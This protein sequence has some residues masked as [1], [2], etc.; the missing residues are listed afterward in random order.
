MSR[1][2]PPWTVAVLTLGLAFSATRGLTVLGTG[3][4]LAGAVGALAVVVL[5]RVDVALVAG[6]L[7]QGTLPTPTWGLA[8]AGLAGLAALAI[9]VDEARLLALGALGALLP[10]PGGHLVPLVAAGLVWAWAPS[11]WRLLAVPTAAAALARGLDPLAV[12][13]GLTVAAGAGEAARRVANARANL[14]AARRLADAGLV[15]A[16]AVGLAGLLAATALDPQ[17]FEAV[18]RWTVWALV[19]GAVAG[20]AHVGAAGSLRADTGP[21]ILL[22]VAWVPV[23]AALGLGLAARVDVL[24]LPGLALLGLATPA[25]ALGLATLLAGP[26]NRSGSDATSGERAV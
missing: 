13:V 14:R 22:A 20:L 15:A 6:G 2:A 26:S 9:H 24:L 23:A 25:A 21:S 8:V 19:G 18:L 10:A 16:P 11:A 1:S 12:A 3:L 17:T 4:V 5:A 7:V